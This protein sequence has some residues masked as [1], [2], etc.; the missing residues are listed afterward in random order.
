MV[1]LIF[2]GTRIFKDFKDFL[3]FTGNDIRVHPC[4]SV[5]RFS[6]EIQILL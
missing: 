6:Y 4:K 5:S 3:G 1:G 2:Y